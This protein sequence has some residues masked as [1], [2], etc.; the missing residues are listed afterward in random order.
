MSTPKRAPRRLSSDSVGQWRLLK[1]NLNDL[2]TRLVIAGFSIGGLIIAQASRGGARPMEKAIAIV[3]AIFVSLVAAV[4]VRYH[5]RLRR[6]PV[7][8]G[9]I[10]ATVIA[11]SDAD[12]NGAHHTGDPNH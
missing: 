5:L 10:G 11:T 6:L 3:G 8:S 4:L 9:S 1:S 12:S 7:N 2:L